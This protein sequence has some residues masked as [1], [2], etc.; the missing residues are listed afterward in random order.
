MNVERFQGLVLLLANQTFVRYYLALDH[1]QY[2]R[3]GIQLYGVTSEL[4]REELR[5]QGFSW[6]VGLNMWIVSR[7]QS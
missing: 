2:K 5:K 3:M 4:L 7:D 6:H 1:P